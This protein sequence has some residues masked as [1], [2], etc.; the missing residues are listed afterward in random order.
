MA[1]KACKACGK[2][3]SSDAKIC[4]NCGKDQR[5][6]FAKHKLISGILVLVILAAI[7]SMTNGSSDK[8]STNNTQETTNTATSNK[9]SEQPKPTPII[10]TVDKL[11]D[12][13]ES[14]AL[15]ASEMYKG[16]YVEVTGKLSNIDSSGEY[17][18][19]D[20]LNDDFALI[21]VQCYITE[22]QKSIIAEL[23]KGQK[24][25]VVG[26]I[27]DVGE[28]LGYSIDVESIK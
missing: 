4:P 22:E 25:T 13:L 27:T 5:N 23:K 8:N 24:V 3:I 14:N 18:N 16:K 20:P 21:N 26:T 7:G 17:F 2:E 10:V 12:D 15:K 28:L 19:I 11:K 9:K 6:W 1:M